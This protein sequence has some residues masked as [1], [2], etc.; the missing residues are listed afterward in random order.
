MRIIAFSVIFTALLILS[1]TGQY[2]YAGSSNIKLSGTLVAEPCILDDGQNGKNITVDFGTIPAKN[3]YSIYS[4]RTWT[5]K[6]KIVLL[7]CDLTLGNLVKVTF[8]GISDSEQPNLL[9]ITSVDGVQHIAIGIESETGV[10]IPINQQTQAY[11]LKNGTTELN[12]MAYVQASKAGIKNKDIGFGNFNAIA[13]FA[14][15]YP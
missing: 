4:N 3:F 1:G 8:N 7:E 2:V 10:E 14:L 13:T 15:E 6:F 11:K 5:Q 12:F 9:A